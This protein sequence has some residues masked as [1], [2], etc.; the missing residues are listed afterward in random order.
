M[1]SGLLSNKERETIRGYLEKG[2]RL[3]GFTVLKYRI[4]KSLPIIEEDL[5]LVKEFLGKIE[6]PGSG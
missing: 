5:A 4:K 3:N 1:R 2:L 6:K